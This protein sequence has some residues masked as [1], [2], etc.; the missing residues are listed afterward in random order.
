MPGNGLSL[1]IGIAGQIDLVGRL[2]VLL[3]RLDEVALTAYVDIFG[4]EIMLDID[5]EL[6]LG[7]VAQ[8]THGGAHHVFAAEILLDRLGLGR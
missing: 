5:A 4:R 8:M 1:A 2:G 6:A 7:Q 3:Q